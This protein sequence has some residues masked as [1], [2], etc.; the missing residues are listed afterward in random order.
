MWK[1]NILSNLMDTAQKKGYLVHVSSEVKPLAYGLKKKN[2]NEFIFKKLLYVLGYRLPNTKFYEGRCYSIIISENGKGP[3]L[4]TGQI[5][6]F[7]RKRHRPK[8]PKHLLCWSGCD[9]PPPDL[10]SWEINRLCDPP[11]GRPLH[12]LLCNSFSLRWTRWT[13]QV[14]LPV[15]FIPPPHCTHC[16]LRHFVHLL[17]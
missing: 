6:C 15:S 9:A 14:Y 12:H 8:L 10:S 1:Q 13:G 2:H 16:T 17:V 7:Y 4:D 11:A 3:K 5:S